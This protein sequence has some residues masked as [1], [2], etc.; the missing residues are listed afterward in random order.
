[1][2]NKWIHIGTFDLDFGDRR[3]HTLKFRLPAVTTSSILFDFEN[4]KANEIQLSKIKL[5]G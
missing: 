2:S 3:G 4:R 5:Y 1:M